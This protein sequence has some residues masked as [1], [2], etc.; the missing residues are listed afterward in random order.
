MDK[1]RIK[2]LIIAASGLLIVLAAVLVIVL[3]DFN[4]S[5]NNTEDDKESANNAVEEKL[6]KTQPPKTEGEGKE[7]SKPAESE[8]PEESVLP[9]DSQKPDETDI[10]KESDIPD[11]TATPQVSDTPNT[12]KKPLAT[13]TPDKT[14]TPEKTEEPVITEKP[15]KTTKP[16]STKKPEKT[17][18]PVKTNKPEATKKPS[19]GN[20]VY[21]D[22]GDGTYNNN[23]AGFDK[24]ELEL[25]N[26]LFDLDNKVTV[27]IDISEEELDKI[28]QDYYNFQNKGNKSP[29]YRVASK[30][31]FTINGKKCE[32]ED[33]G[34]RMKGNT[35]RRELYSIDGGNKRYYQTHFK[36]SFDETFDKEEYYG[37]EARVWSS[38]A[39]RDERKD[40]TFATLSSMELKYN[41]TMDGTYA[42]EVY[43][44][45]LFRANGV[46]AQN[47]NKAAFTMA[48]MDFGV[49]TIYEPVDKKFIKR[50][51]PEEDWDGDLYKAQWTYNG[52]D[53]SKRCTYG[54]E[55]ETKGMFF[56]YDLKT[57]KKT[58]VHESIKNLINKINGSIS[59]EEFSKIIDVDYFTRYAAC[60]YFTGCPDDMRN[61]YN[62]YLVYFKKSDGKAIF[63]PYDYDRCLGM[64]D[65][66]NPDGNCMTGMSPFSDCAV[67]NGWDKKVNNIF[68]NVVVDGSYYQSEYKEEL[69]KLLNSDWLTAEKFNEYAEIIKDNY[70][71]E[72]IPEYN[73]KS[74]DEKA[75]GFASNNRNGNMDIQNYF[76]KIIAKCKSEM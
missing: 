52:A 35:S 27:N 15:E 23:A 13:G 21:A 55:D 40:R 28:Q 76:S 71:N 20:A 47:A 75:L 17:N 31:T 4:T 73:I 74:C 53:F 37:D 64:V 39:E 18:E 30:V 66:Y 3:G 61:N 11:D 67:G 25:Y 43:A 42:C 19:G 58:S 56:N 57:N 9:K 12:S 32:I 38:K 33:V 54:I 2:K 45:D 8:K 41:R 16:E 70:S 60:C 6:E 36:L 26:K 48:G 68:K 7:S 46:L 50:Y 62:N 72:V 29:I 44:L 1:G 10:P 5:D 34:I 65:G 69:T 24:K 49:Y 59:K 63:I 22:T 14:A 51:L